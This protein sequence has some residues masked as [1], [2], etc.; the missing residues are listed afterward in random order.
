MICL[1]LCGATHR[2]SVMACIFF[3]MAATHLVSLTLIFSEHLQRCSSSCP[4]R[5]FRFGILLHTW[6][7]GSRTALWRIGWHNT[8][9]MLIY[10]LAFVTGIGLLF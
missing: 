2:P 3:K 8:M 1:A 10:W 6:I 7:K 4:L 9:L 5:V